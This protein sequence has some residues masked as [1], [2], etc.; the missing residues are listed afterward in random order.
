M[1]YSLAEAATA[2]GKSKMTIQ[3]AIKSGK[4]SASR[5]DDES[6]DIDPSELHTV[7]PP[8]SVLEA[9]NDNKVRD[10]IPNDMMVLRLELKVR[11][12]KIASIEAE[13]ER[14]RHQLESQIDDLRQRLDSEGEE[15]RRLTAL[16]TDQRQPL[17]PKPAE[18]SQPQKPAPK[19][20]RGFLHRL[21]G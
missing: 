15:R 20:L 6:Y 9:K 2:S 16:L 19:G 13:R 7:F 10:D 11:D 12:E 8:V 5:R 1:G 17:Q 4:L 14:E 18:A 21:T 3:R